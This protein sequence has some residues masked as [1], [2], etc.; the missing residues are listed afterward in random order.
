MSV[1][2]QIVLRREGAQVGKFS[3]WMSSFKVVDFKTEEA[4]RTRLAELKSVE[5]KIGGWPL[6]KFQIDVPN[7]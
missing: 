7:R 2:P 4:S 1:R 6:D 3:L 5:Q